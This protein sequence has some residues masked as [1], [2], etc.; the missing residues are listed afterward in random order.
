MNLTVGRCSLSYAQRVVTE[1]HYLHRP[2]HPR[3]NPFAYSVKLDGETVGVIILA[4]PHFI[5]QRGLFGYENLPTKWQTLM[6]A[7]VWLEPRVQVRQ[8]NGHASNIASAALARMLRCVQADWLQHHPPRFLDQPYHI[9]LILAYAD[10]SVNHEGTI[11][12]AANFRHFGDTTNTR[13]RH[14]TRGECNGALKHL[15]VY[16]LPEPRWTVQ[17]LLTMGTDRCTLTVSD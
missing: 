14:T 10:T 2:V 4:T 12:K 8:A 17:T 13:R 15:Y 1:R 3:A 16:E 11:Y 9:R 5:K 6:I 7:R